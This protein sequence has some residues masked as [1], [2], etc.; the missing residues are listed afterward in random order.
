MTRFL[1]AEKTE[2]ARNLP[3]YDR[4]Q[5]DIDAALVDARRSTTT[6]Q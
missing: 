1:A 3:E 2:R 4:H 6:K 5:N